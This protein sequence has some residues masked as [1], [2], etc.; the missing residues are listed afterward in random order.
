MLHLFEPA[1]CHSQPVSQQTKEKHSHQ[2]FLLNQTKL[3]LDLKVVPLNSFHRLYQEY[4]NILGNY[5]LQ[6]FTLKENRD[7]GHEKHFFHRASEGNKR[8]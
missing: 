1:F 8:K 2:L 5:C 3:M 4:C 7:E 6:I